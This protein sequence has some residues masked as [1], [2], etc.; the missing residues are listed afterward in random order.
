MK[1]TIYIY[2][3]EDKDIC[4]IC[5]DKLNTQ[6]TFQIH[7]C[8]HIFHSN[9]LLNWFTTGNLKCP[10]CNY[11]NFNNNLHS[12]EKKIKFKIISTY[13]KRKDA[14]IEIVKKINYIKT[15]NNKINEMTKELKL[16]KNQ[17]GEYNILD[18]KIKN[19]NNKI[20]ALKNKL[21]E[22][23]DELLYSINVIPFLINKK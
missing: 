2:N 19:I 3:N 4:A 10:Y 9:C 7:E 22:F 8:K 17:K 15:L 1:E 12:K 20:W 14:N 11:S 6:Q 13:C 18:K 21:I 23:K 5:H 16:I